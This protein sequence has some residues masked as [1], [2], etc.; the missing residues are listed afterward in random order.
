MKHQ[1][2]PQILL[3][4]DS[5]QQLPALLEGHK[6]LLVHAHRPV[7]DGLLEQVRVLLTS[8]HIQHENLGQILPNPKYRSVKRG[9]RHCRRTDCDFILSLGGGS[10]LQ[11]ARGI[12][13]G[14]RFKGDIRS[15][16]TGKSRPG[17]ALPVACVLTNPA[18]G[19]ELTDACT[20]V[21]K[22]KQRTIHAPQA[23]CRFAILDP[24]LSILPWYPTMN[25]G[26]ALYV[27]AFAAALSSREPDLTACVDVMKRVLECIR[28]LSTDLSDLEA[29]S[30][31]FEAG[32]LSH[33]LKSTDPT[34]YI[35][36]AQDLAFACSL[37]EGTAL[38]SLFPAWL[39]SLART[40]NERLETIARLVYGNGTDLLTQTSQ[41][42]GDMKLAGSLPE[43]GLSLSRKELKSFT[44]SRYLQKILLAANK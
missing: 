37:P 12:A 33:K 22:G 21:L 23:A 2:T 43:A 14:V 38:S 30:A 35:Q 41:L 24:R 3:G 27:R 39:H 1:S 18:T 44:D 34:G 11:C 9:I 28:S 7:E 10:T 25:Q 29:R 42:L 17:K 31:L 26:F 40:D 15:F 16:W 32:V 4:P 20:L 8:H 19:D 6:V 36:L 13:L 5:L